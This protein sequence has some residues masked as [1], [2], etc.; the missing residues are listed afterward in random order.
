MR[1][2]NAYCRDHNAEHC[3]NSETAYFD[4]LGDG[5]AAPA[6]SG[7]ENIFKV[8]VPALTTA[9]MQN[10]LTK[11]NVARL[12]AG[13]SPVTAADFAA[14]YQPT[15]ANVAVGPDRT[16]TQLIFGAMALGGLYFGAR[17]FMNQRGR[18]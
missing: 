1:M 5:E 7:W 3:F 17:L 10:Q 9:Y 13:Q 15:A 4:G 18:R 14:N 6:A 11:L 2:Q 16:A 8:A 12:N